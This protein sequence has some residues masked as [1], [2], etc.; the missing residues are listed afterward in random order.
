MGHKGLK[1]NSLYC[2]YLATSSENNTFPIRGITPHPLQHPHCRH[3]TILITQRST[4]ALPVRHTRPKPGRSKYLLPKG[5]QNKAT[6]KTSLLNP[7]LR[8]ASPFRPL[9]KAG[10]SWT[11]LPS[12]TSFCPSGFTVPCRSL[13]PVGWVA[14]FH[15]AART[16][17]NMPK[18]FSHL[19]SSETENYFI[20]TP[21][22]PQ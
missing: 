11:L 12:P 18:T 13:V 16:T 17:G 22:G 1:T 4:E 5:T 2:L 7:Y 14:F 9:P 3:A 15:L 8:F 21:N 19:S 20:F 10:E 6:P